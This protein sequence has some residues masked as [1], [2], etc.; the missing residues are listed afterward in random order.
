MEIQ[1]EDNVNFAIEVNIVILQSTRV[2]MKDFIALS[3]V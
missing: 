2:L 3:I 1:K